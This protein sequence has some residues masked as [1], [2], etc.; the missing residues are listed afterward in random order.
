MLSSRVGPLAFIAAGLASAAIGMALVAVAPNA[1]LLAAGILIAGSSA[2]WTWAPYNDAVDRLAPAN[3]EQRV[4]SIISTGTTI[5]IIATGVTALAFGA[6]WRW[7]WVVFVVA[8]GAALLPNLRTL[9]GL[10]PRP[11]SS[12]RRHGAGDAVAPN[13]SSWRRFVRPEVAPL[14]LVAA[15]FGVVS[16][17]YFAFAVDVIVSVG[18]DRTFAGPM[19][20][21]ILGAAGIAGVATGDAVARFGARSVLLATLAGLGV[22]AVLLGLA[23]GAWP[24]IALSA[25]LH[26]AG[27]MVM[28]ALLAIW[29]AAVFP[30]RPAA[31]FSATLFVFG[32]G[33]TLGPIVL[34]ALAGALTLQGVF[35]A[36]GA[37]AWLTALIEPPAL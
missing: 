5:G 19:L 14:F 6:S 16:S 27:V 18:M 24:A 10:E 1:P 34:S 3:R 13:S 32:V 36:A 28:S 17:F 33:L 26:G 37:V 9:R 20:Y 11:A 12:R 35:V 22:A 23:P 7:A 15:S 8:A 31:G 2:G 30:A 4:L 29:N 25:A 21:V